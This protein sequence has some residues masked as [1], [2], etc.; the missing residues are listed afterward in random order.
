MANS[1][2]VNSEVARLG[3]RAYATKKKVSSGR[4]KSIV[5]QAHS[6]GFS[7]DSFLDTNIPNSLKER[8]KAGIQAQATKT[9]TEAYKPVEKEYSQQEERVKSIDAKRSRDNQYYLD[10]LTART[11]ELN[12]H[13][14]AADQQMLDRGKQI[15]DETAAQ[16]GALRDQLIAGASQTPGNVS[17]PQQ[18]TAFDTS[19][20]SKRS[21]ESVANA[22]QQTANMVGSSEKR[23]AG[24]QAINFAQ[25]AAA[26]AQRHSDTANSLK[27]VADGRTK[28]ALAKSADASKEVSR[29]LDQ[30]IDKANSNREFSAALQK[31]GIAQD[32][33][34]QRDDAAH[35][36]SADKA[37][38]RAL[39]ARVAARIAS[40]RD[41]EI[42]LK[43]D[44]LKI[45]WYKA[46]HGGKSKGNHQDPQVRFED[47][48]ASLAAQDFFIPS[49]D[50]KSEKPVTNKSEYVKNRREQMVAALMKKD[51]V[52]REMA[53]RAVDAFIQHGGGDPGSY[54]GYKQ[55]KTH[56]PNP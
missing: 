25:I 9:I 3:A 37:R 56:G 7:V 11:G 19:A 5:K 35:M 49:K 55:K 6:R 4:W 29:L 32:S 38:D 24:D 16:Q 42:N 1:A 26:E 41:Q 51:K 47:A 30:E 46:K 54:T 14:K 44:K 48:V 43:G 2:V 20:D 22:R 10:W 33:I 8:T 36:N 53:S 34:Q 13:A 21:L 23:A 18:A 28:T 17:N 40:Q 31:L 15:Q 45:D 50:G 52:S 27:D 39:R 12:T